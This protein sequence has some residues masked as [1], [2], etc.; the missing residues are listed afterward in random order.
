MRA[1]WT[2]L[3]CALVL[4][5]NVDAAGELRLHVNESNSSLRDHVEQEPLQQQQQSLPG[6]TFNLKVLVDDVLN[7]QR[8]SQAVVEVFVNY[9]RNNTALSGQDGSA[10]L[11]VP[12][13]SGLP[14]TVV[15]SKV[16][17]ISTL[18]HCKTSRV[19]IFSSLTM[20]LTGLNQGN[21]W[22][23]EDSVHITHK[24]NDVSSQPAVRFPKS[25]L[26]LTHSSNITSVTAYLTILK[27]R[28]QQDGSLNTLGITSSKSGYVSVELR[29]VAAVSVQLFSGDTELHVSG[30]VEI[31]L[32]VSDSCGL[33]ASNVV[34]A[35]FFNRTLGGWM[36]KGLGKVTLVDGK[37]VW[38]F[39]A[40]HLGYWIAA[41][42]PS[43]KGIFGLAITVDFISH[44]A[45]FL[46]VFLG[47]T[48]LVVFCILV[49]LLYYCR[50]E[51]IKKKGRKIPVVMKRDQTTSTYTD[52]VSEASSGNARRKDVLN[53]A[54]TEMGKN[55]LTAAFISMHNSD[56][57]VNPGAVAIAVEC[58]ELELKTH[59]SD[60][61]FIHRTSD[62]DGAP[63]SLPDSLFF[64]NHPIAILPAPAFFHLEER[65]EPAQKSKS[66]TLPRAGAFT[67]TATEPANLDSFTQTLSKA[68]SAAQSQAVDTDNQLGGSEAAQAANTASTARGSFNIPESAS[69]PGT[70]NKI[71]GSRNSARILSGFSKI[72]SPQPPRAWF[73]SLEGKPAAEIHRAATD[74]QRRRRPIESRETSLDSGVDM[75]E[76]NQASGR[77]A[78]TLD[79]NAT[80]VK[81]TS[82]SKHTHPSSEK[83][84]HP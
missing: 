38:K 30:P 79:R 44:H 46:M 63:T 6:S 1:C 62:Q 37:L 67:S 65:P 81:S 32:S 36:R 29:P 25:L 35:W 4:C 17:Y 78:G 28:S 9:T 75:S 61:A 31:S 53:P 22:L 66:A 18:L 58:D 57:L 5:R 34:P 74:Q 68:P 59:L 8:L 39:T 43:N 41:P 54:F 40:S 52:E 2:S 14:V 72:P 71:G 23:F 45:L 77:R 10:L 82:N 12:F 7:G 49:G 69:V 20:S 56:V 33:H 13:H 27:A 48:L 64:Y 83:Q 70:L 16:G 26:N 76:L 3:L 21:I 60:L 47:G 51:P 50:R 80:F 15:A 19:P 84:D 55:Q 73:V 42:L 11:H 24:T